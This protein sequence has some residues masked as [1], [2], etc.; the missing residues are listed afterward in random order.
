MLKLAGAAGGL[1]MAGGIH[2]AQAQAGKRI[3]QFAPELDNIISTSEPI[4]ELGTG[5]GGGGNTEGP[6]WWKEGGYLLFSEI[7]KD[8]RLKYTPGQ[9]VTVAREDTHGANGLTRDRQGRLVICEGWTR[10]VTREESD[11]SF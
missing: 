6:V 7:G 8:R 3:E 1:A 4:L 5:F 11:G 9:G 10:R 2:G